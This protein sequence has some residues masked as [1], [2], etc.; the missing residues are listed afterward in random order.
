MKSSPDLLSRKGFLTETVATVHSHRIMKKAIIAITISAIA[1]TIAHRASAD[2]GVYISVENEAQKAVV[3]KSLK[4]I[5]PQNYRL[6][7][8]DANGKT[9]VRGSAPVSEIAMLESK[10]GAKNAQRGPF[11]KL[12]IVGSLHLSS[13][14]DP[15]TTAR[16]KAELAKVGGNFEVKKVDMPAKKE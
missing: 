14:Y 16:L 9:S 11:K 4:G 10:A 7:F 2:P 13:F 8:E 5:P 15:P 6:T 12:R 1:G 3:E